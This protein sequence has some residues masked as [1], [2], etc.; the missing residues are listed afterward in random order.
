MMKVREITGWEA[1]CARCGRQDRFRR[2]FV[3]AWLWLVLHRHADRWLW[4]RRAVDGWEVKGWIVEC[5]RCGQFNHHWSLPAA[6]WWTLRHRC[7]D[8]LPKARAL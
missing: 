1:V 3:A 7:G 2:S 6:E 5:V 8:R 4:S